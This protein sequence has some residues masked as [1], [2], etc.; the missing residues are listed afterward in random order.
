MM[1][2]GRHPNI[3]LLSYSEVEQV[4]G[5]VG[6][7]DVRIRKRAR[8]VNEDLCTGCG[9]CQEKCPDARCWIPPMRPGW[10][11]ARP[12]I[13]PLPRSIPSYPVLDREHCLYFTKG[14]LQAVRALLSHRRDRL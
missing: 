1:D 6:Q 5:F 7:F 2:A 14:T 3:T 8:S 13:A 11:N 12:S 4:S 10:A 9:M